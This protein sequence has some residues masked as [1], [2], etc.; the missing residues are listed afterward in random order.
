MQA[1][2]ITTDAR[3]NGESILGLIVSRIIDGGV[4]GVNNLELYT[5]TAFKHIPSELWEDGFKTLE[6]YARTKNCY[7]VVA[8][9]DNKR[10]L[11]M[12]DRLGWS[13]EYTFL[14]KEVEYN[15]DV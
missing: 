13:S 4:T 6:K 8:Y 2:V 12:A 15:E 9:S 7:R 14:T 3:V 5:I 1:W 11:D 10:V